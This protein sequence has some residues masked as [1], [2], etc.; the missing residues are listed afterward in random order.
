MLRIFLKGYFD[1]DTDCVLVH[2]V[3]YFDLEF[4]ERNLPNQY[5]KKRNFLRE[6]TFTFFLS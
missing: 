1:F 2:L 3:K 6:R 4:I 5:F